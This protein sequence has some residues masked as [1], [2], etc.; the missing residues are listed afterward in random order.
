MNKR[1]GI[2]TK[3]ISL[4]LSVSLLL[5]QSSMAWAQVTWSQQQIDQQTADPIV[6]QPP[7]KEAPAQPQALGFDITAPTILHTPPI[8]K[9]VA[10]TTQSV[11]AEI[12][13]NVKVETAVLMHRNSTADFYSTIVMS[14]DVT[15]STWLATFDTNTEDTLVHYYIVAQ[16]ID[17]NR[18]Q[19]GSE[20]NP[21]TLQLQ[22]PER[23]AAAVPVDKDNRNNW[24]AI[25]LG[26]LAVI[27][28]M[29]GS[30]GGNDGIVQS[31]GDCCTVTFTAPNVTD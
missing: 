27:A 11:T 3:F 2:T 14:A 26:V 29:S 23:F 21:L 18:V 12:Q 20:T 5:T 1:T 9:G 8:T 31:D 6:E 13:D 16:D 19:K 28:I 10:G 7:T 30:G 24:L 4:L 22:R 17:G 25:G 15:E